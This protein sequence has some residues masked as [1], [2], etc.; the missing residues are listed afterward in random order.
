MLDDFAVAQE[1]NVVFR[2]HDSPDLGEERPHVLVAVTLAGRVVSGGRTSRRT[3][4]TRDKRLDLLAEADSLGTQAQNRRRC[5][6]D[7]DAGS[8]RRCHR[9]R[10]APA[11][12]RQNRINCFMGSVPLPA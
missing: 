10:S 6:G 5:C 11:V 2:R 12:A 9:A 8:P 3:V 4:P 1:Q 7:P